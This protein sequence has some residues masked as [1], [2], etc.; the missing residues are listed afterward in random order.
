[1]GGA[2]ATCPTQLESNS[3][4]GLHSKPLVRVPNLEILLMLA[5]QLP[6][7]ANT[8]KLRSEIGDRSLLKLAFSEGSAVALLVSYESRSAQLSRCLNLQSTQNSGL[9]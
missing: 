7:R 1:M 2:D 5:Y 4:S 3:C 6:A 8:L 9:C